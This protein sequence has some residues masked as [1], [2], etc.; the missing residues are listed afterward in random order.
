MS[1]KD[2]SLEI[3]PDEGFEKNDFFGHKKFGEQ[4]ANLLFN[5]EHP[6]TIAIDGQWGQG[7]TTFLKMWAGHLRKMNFPVIEFDAFA[8]DFYDDPFV[9]LAGELVE[10]A[11]PFKSVTDDIKGKAGKVG[12]ALLKGTIKIGV[13]ALSVGLLDGHTVDQIKEDLS[14]SLSDYAEKQVEVLLENYQK[15]KGE[16]EAF[17]EALIQ[18]PNKLQ[19]G[20]KFEDDV[21]INA[22]PLIF[23][24]DE[25]DRCRPDYAL[26]LLERVK[27]FYSVK[28]VHFVFGMNVRQLEHSV[29]SS[30]GIGIDA[31]DY[32]QK[33]FTIINLPQKSGYNK[34]TRVEL[35]TNKILSKKFTHIAQPYIINYLILKNPSNRQ[36]EHLS[37]SINLICNDNISNN[38][39]T[40]LVYLIC[41]KIF[42]EEIYNNI[43]FGKITPQHSGSILTMFSPGVEGNLSWLGDFFAGKDLHRINAHSNL[44]IHQ[45]YISWE[46]VIGD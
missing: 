32:L 15:E 9:P 27:H 45:H 20:P 2:Y 10:I 31:K 28:N 11:K 33:F 24:I 29:K 30:Y 14:D 21:P 1:L 38:M 42:D 35:Y 34:P 37:D 26:R 23:I 40:Y 6:L 46:N 25:L 13:K 44:S 36:L 8:S 19:S 12:A 16:F 39:N 43:I 18:L 3:S 4:I 7:K 17:R 22:K 41:L 5:S